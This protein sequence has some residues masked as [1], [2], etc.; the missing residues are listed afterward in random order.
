MVLN[1]LSS[2][3]YLMTDASETGVARN[4]GRGVRRP[5]RAASRRAPQATKNPDE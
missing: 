1:E 3:L 4:L 5:E 2:Q